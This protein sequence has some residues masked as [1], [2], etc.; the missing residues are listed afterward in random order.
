ML[1]VICKRYLQALLDDVVRADVRHLLFKSTSFDDE[2]C[3]EH[4]PESDAPLL[5]AEFKR[6]CS[7][8]FL[9]TPNGWQGSGL[10]ALHDKH[11]LEHQSQFN[12][13]DLWASGGVKVKGS[14]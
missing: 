10:A 11:L 6:V 5:L 13:D 14:R 9:T 3:I 7:H 4:L 8:V 1:N 12:P 2:L